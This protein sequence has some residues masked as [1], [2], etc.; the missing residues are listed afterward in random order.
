MKGLKIKDALDY[1][2]IFTS[3]HEAAHAICALYN[4]FQVFNVNVRA[5]DAKTR[6]EKDGATNWYITKYVEDTELK[7]TVLVFELQAMYAGLLGE[8][9]LYKY[10]SGSPKLPMNLKVGLSY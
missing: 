10:I 2:L 1:E 5:I 9:I 4:F 8:R 6:E 7:K 3:F